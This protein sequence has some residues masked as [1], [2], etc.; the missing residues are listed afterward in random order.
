MNIIIFQWYR[1]DKISKQD[2]FSGIAAREVDWA[3]GISTQNPATSSTQPLLLLLYIDSNDNLLKKM[4]P[5]LII[6][7]LERSYIISVHGPS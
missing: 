7:N 5:D 3:L 2:D 6:K 1:D 4:E